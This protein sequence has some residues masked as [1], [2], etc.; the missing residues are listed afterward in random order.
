MLF[1]PFIGL[2]HQLEWVF[3]IEG[4]YACKNPIGSIVT[5]KTA[6]EVSTSV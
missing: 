6:G 5:P 4:A 3:R 2:Y 1:A